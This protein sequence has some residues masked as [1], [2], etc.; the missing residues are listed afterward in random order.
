MYLVANNS[1]AHARVAEFVGTGD[2]AARW[3]IDEAAGVGDSGRIGLIEI[4]PA[5]SARLTPEAGREQMLFVLR[6]G[7][8]V[9]SD[10][11]DADV[12]GESVM[13]L[14]GRQTLALE[15]GH[16]GLRLLLVQ[17]GGAAATGRM[18]IMSLGEVENAPFHK[19][20]LGFIHVAARW[21]V[22]GNAAR[23][24]A[25]VIGQSTF[26]SGAAHL[27]HRHDHGDEFFYVFDGQGAHLVEGGEVAMA[28]G[29]VVLAPR[30][31]WHGFR[32][33]GDRPVRAIFGWFGVTS[34]E[35]AGYE[36]HP[37][38]AAASFNNGAV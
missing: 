16:S 1:P 22:G 17:G 34:L 2:A 23:S 18:Q 15:A 26:V 12:R 11:V 13:F 3:L 32:N 37:D 8:Q 19:P 29:D 31:E 36:V 25:L 35:E 10:G 4:G 20:E 7:A 9:R 5:G 30:R 33:T 21:L 14:P 38:V 27:L 28:A 24:A 6:G